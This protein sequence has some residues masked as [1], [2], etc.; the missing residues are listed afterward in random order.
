MA[1]LRYWRNNRFYVFHWFDLMYSMLRV[2]MEKVLSKQ[3][4]S[5]INYCGKI[6]YL[7]KKLGTFILFSCIRGK[8]GFNNHH[9]VHCLRLQTWLAIIYF[10]QSFHFI[11]KL[12]TVGETVDFLLLVR[13]KDKGGLIYPSPDVVKI[14]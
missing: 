11:K 10:T 3:L 1:I 5:A 8:N 12:V 14:L 4:G 6:S 2:L 7:P 9:D 13:F